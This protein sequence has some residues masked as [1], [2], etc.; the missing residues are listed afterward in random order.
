MESTKS[1]KGQQKFLGS[2]FKTSFWLQFHN[3]G[4]KL[5]TG[6]ARLPLKL[7][8]AIKISLLSRRLSIKICFAR[9]SR[10]SKISPYSQVLRPL[11]VLFFSIFFLLPGVVTAASVAIS[12]I[13]ITGGTG[14]TTDDFIELYNQSD[15]SF[16]LKGYRLVKRTASAG[17]LD[18][19]I[20]SWT[21]DTII[22]ARG[23]YLW[24][25]SSYSAIPI[26]PDS[27][28]SASIAD[29]N[30]VA[31]RLGA[32]D[33]GEIIDSVAWGSALNGFTVVSTENPGAGQAL[34]RQDLLS[35]SQ[36]FIIANSSP[37]NISITFPENFTPPQATTT[38]STTDTLTDNQNNSTTT[39]ALDQQENNQNNSG[40]SAAVQTSQSKPGFI[41]LSEIYAN[42]PGDDSGKEAVE[43][44]NIGAEAVDVGGWYLGDK[45][46]S[47]VKS[48]AYQLPPTIINPGA[49]A[50]F[51]IPKGYFAFN[52]TGGDEANL[53]FT[54]KTLADK[55]SYSDAAPEG[56]SLQK[57]S[58][59]WA[60]AS[61]TLG[62]KNFLP[63][64][65]IFSNPGIFINEIMANPVGADDGKEW[66]EIFNS[67][68]DNVSLKGF[69]LDDGDGAIG[70]S[71]WT[72]DDK[73]IILAESYFVLNIP[74]DKFSLDNTKDTVRLFNPARQLVEQ[75]GFEKAPEGQSYSKDSSGKWQYGIPT[76]GQKNA[77]DIELPK[78]IIT[79]ILPYPEKND[80]EFVEIK[81]VGEKEYPLAGLVLHLGNS[82]K[83]LDTQSVL[84]PGEFY[85]VYEDELP[86]KLRNSGQSV[87]LT[88]FLGRE[89]DKVTYGKAE[90]GMA[91]AQ[92]A[93]DEYLWTEKPTP[94]KP[95]EMVLSAATGS[96]SQKEAS[97]VKKTVSDK[98]LNKAYALALKNSEQM[99]QEIQN[100]KQQVVDLNNKLDDLAIPS[101]EPT[102]AL[103]SDGKN[104]PTNKKIVG[105]KY[106]VI[107]ILSLLALAVLVK[108]FY[109][110]NRP[111][112]I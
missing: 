67:S 4:V 106:L 104:N 15:T 61:P 93:G 112:E 57:I 85:A 9:L 63:A 13:Q 79:E 105:I 90:M 111:S 96:A 39:P 91:Y 44:E 99:L 50:V 69:I 94:G 81:N 5:A 28:T 27:A 92:T 2:G 107:A 73:A 80:E 1:A 22:P 89:I 51:V 10:N 45:S 30:G 3:F 62:Q 17:S 42:P 86:A 52:N 59:K 21:D 40:S 65:S 32:S 95:N 11:P 7:H 84:R 54:D 53:Y 38:T 71:A 110:D 77:A 87:S 66:V 18:S 34:V 64:E 56:K 43:L 101:I 58:G 68:K 98:E 8:S 31:I 48:N 23:F 109:L 24:A 12:Q 75:V 103:A 88:D 33:S 26:A 41:K 36:N 78:I 14:H 25:N 46:D 70:S 55:A 19:L 6:R 60:W 37:R 102:K 35:P 29:N 74:E 108:R 100:L 82:S 20:K 49:F 83:I 72:L 47:G 97:A 76:P 16:N